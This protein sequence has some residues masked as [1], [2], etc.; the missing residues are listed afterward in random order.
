[1]TALAHSDHGV[2]ALP[3][4]APRVDQ[5]AIALPADVELLSDNDQWT[6][7]FNFTSESGR[8]YRVAQRKYNPKTGTGGWWACDC[9]SYKTRRKDSRTGKVCKHMKAMGLPGN[10]E[11]LFIGRLLPGGYDGPQVGSGTLTNSEAAQITAKQR[12]AKPELAP[13]SAE[14]L[15][16]F[17]VVGKTFGIKDD[18]KALGGRW[19]KAHKCWVMPN[20]SAFDQAIAL[21][22]GGSSAPRKAAPTAAPVAALP[23][24]LKPDVTMK[25]GKIVVT[26]DAAQAQQVFALL[27]QIS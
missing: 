21:M 13:A 2:P 22:K 9:P 15:P 16:E 11:P 7:R 6:N 12:K 10:H 19:N 20:Q 3:A 24:G 23:T 8:V 18:L 14:S 25:D 5:E 17:A 1:M 4:G 26:F 27:A